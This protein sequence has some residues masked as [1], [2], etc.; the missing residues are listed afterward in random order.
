MICQLRTGSTN[1][2]SGA[3]E[4]HTFSPGYVHT[5]LVER[6]L[7]SFH[8]T[9]VGF[10]LFDAEFY[11][12][13]DGIIFNIDILQ[14]LGYALFSKFSRPNSCKLDCRFMLATNVLHSSC[15]V[16][17]GFIFPALQL[18]YMDR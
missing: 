1:A 17:L 9:D 11:A 12:L 10:S 14:F 16:P 13:F 3:T 18:M 2:K 6:L 7:G 15:R 5:V 8:C 4:S